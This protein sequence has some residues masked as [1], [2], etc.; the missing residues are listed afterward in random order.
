MYRAYLIDMMR[1]WRES[2]ARPRGAATSAVLS[3]AFH[4]TL[5]CGAVI[6]TLPAPGL[7]EN[8]LANRVFYIPPPK[9]PPAMAATHETLRFIELSTPGPGEGAGPA[10]F[11]PEETFATRPESPQPGDSGTA[12]VT[13]PATAAAPGEDSVFTEIEVDTRTN[14]MRLDLRTAVKVTRGSS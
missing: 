6:A 2:Y 4:V 11:R 8:S 13:A 3:V 5:V 9:R 1:L 12:P 7:D 10:S 14:L